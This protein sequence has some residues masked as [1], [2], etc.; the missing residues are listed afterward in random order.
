MPTDSDRDESSAGED[1]SRIWTSLAGREEVLSMEQFRVD[2][3]WT[4]SHYRELQGQYPRC[5]VAVYQGQVVATNKRDQASLIRTL[6][7][8]GLPLEQV[9]VRYIHAKGEGRSQIL[10]RAA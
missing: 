10:L 5:W 4:S 1:P 2:C 6:Q 7:S 3:E 9:L 8:K